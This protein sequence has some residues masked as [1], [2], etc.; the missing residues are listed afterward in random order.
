MNRIF[1]WRQSLKTRVTLLTLVIFTISIWSLAFFASRMLREDMQRLS[2]EQQFSTVSFMAAQLNSELNARVQA[3]E[4]LAEKIPPA[5]ISSPASLQ[6]VLEQHEDLHKLFNAGLIITGLD[7]IA[8]ADFPLSSGRIGINYSDRD[9]M[10]SALK[11]GKTVFGRPVMGKKSNAPVLVMTAPIRGYTGNV[12]GALTGGTN[13]GLPNFLDKYTEN[14]NGKAGGFLIVS[15]NDRLV[16]TA[17][18]KSMSMEPS[19]PPGVNPI[20]DRFLKGFEGSVIFTNPQAVEQLVSIKGVPIANWYITAHLPITEAL[21]PIRTMLVNITLATLFLTLISGALIWLLLRRQL[22]PLFFTARTLATYASNDQVPPPLPIKYPDEIGQLISGFNQLLGKLGQREEQVRKMAFHDSL[23]GLPNRRLLE[24]RLN[25]AMAASKRSGCYS[26]LIFLDLDNF[27][28]LNDI[29]GHEAGDL[30]LVEVA[31]RLKAGVRE[32]DTVARIG[33]DEFVLIIS[34]LA[35]DRAESIVQARI[36]AEK[37]RSS[38]AETYQLTIQHEGEAENTV[39]HHCSASL[40]VVLF[41]NHEAS[42]EDLFKW[43]DSAMYQAKDGGRNMIQFASRTTHSEPLD[44]RP[45][46]STSFVRLS[47]HSSYECGHALI[48]AQHRGLFADANELLNAI[49]AQQSREEVA[50]LI[51]GLIHDVVQHFKDEESILN[52]IGFPDVEQHAAIHHTL[53]DKAVEL[54]GCFNA[55]TLELG[56]LFDFLATDVVAK[57]MLGKDREFFAYLETKR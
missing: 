55:G 5:I 44:I 29:H 31:Q 23:T 32:S 38:L 41:L 49:L 45:S 54:L 8:I 12:I 30:L 11:E 48:D 10:I 4:N 21:A 16:V 57:H 27:K 6:T 19:P 25:Q 15:R 43:A 56:K 17:T 24:D 33:G 14:P 20:I 50:T 18:D 36:V 3:L 34:Q 35:T 46:S 40:G 39:E 1:F 9:F 37:I 52:H 26:A 42:R 53:T 7:G 13:L 28:P 22:A 47:W 2:G 51:D